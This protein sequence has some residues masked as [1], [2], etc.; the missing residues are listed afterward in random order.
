M[1]TSKETQECE[2]S[3]Q[4]IRE[5]IWNKHLKNNIFRI[6]EEH[7][8][9]KTKKTTQLLNGQNIWTSNRRRHR[10]GHEHMEKWSSSLVTTV[11]SINPLRMME[12]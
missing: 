4:R 5:N 9:V 2:K 10:N 11:D 1:C 8:Q 3:S 7:L 12:P 6:C